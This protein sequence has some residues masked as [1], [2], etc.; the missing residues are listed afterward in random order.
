MKLTKR[1]R[2]NLAKI[3]ADIGKL[4]I[5]IVVL[6]Q[7]VSPIGFSIFKLIIGA[8]LAMV[9]IIVVMVIDPGVC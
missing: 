9:C 1:R 5:A 7:W 3:I 4:L 2:E 6:G 8:M